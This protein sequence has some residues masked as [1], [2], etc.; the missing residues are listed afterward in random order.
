M[1]F[2]DSLFGKKEKPAPIEEPAASDDADAVVDVIFERA[3]AELQLKT[4]AAMGLWGLGSGESWAA[5]LEAGTITF[6]NAKGWEINAPVQ[7]IGTLN[8]ADGTWLWGWDHPSVPAPVSLHAGLVRDFGA[9]HGL[10]A[11][12]TR[13]IEA[14]ETDGWTFAAL[15]CH[16]AGA[17]G[18]YRGP[19]GDAL[20]FMTYGEVSIRDPNA[21]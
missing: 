9:Q 10:E 13:K 21:G 12:T 6:V 17:Q 15:A 7:V 2:L 4:E 18:A 14:D 5:D 20:V 8:T 16:L 11:L 19:A 1:K 3:D